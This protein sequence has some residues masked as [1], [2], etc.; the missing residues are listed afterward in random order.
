MHS[1]RSLVT[2]TLFFEAKA[3]NSEGSTSAASHSD[4][5]HFNNGFGGK[6]AN[7]CILATCPLGKG[8]MTVADSVDETEES[9]DSLPLSF[10]DSG[11][12]CVSVCTSGGCNADSA[13]CTTGN[14][15]SVLALEV[16]VW[17]ISCVDPGS[18]SKNLGL[19]FKLVLG[20]IRAISGCPVMSN[21]GISVP[22]MY[23]LFALKSMTSPTSAIAPALRRPGH[24]TSTMATQST[25]QSVALKQIGQQHA[26]V[27]LTTFPLPNRNCSSHSSNL[28]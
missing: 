21:K 6:F 17:A 28:T 9:S 1:F 22:C 20:W 4:G 26:C 15:L 3:L 23:I 11:S 16:L 2:I 5:L 18:F 12:E 19:C 13:T 7:S 27:A 10:S 25:C 8:N 14:C 24:G